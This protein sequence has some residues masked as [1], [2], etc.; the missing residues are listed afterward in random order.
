MV[1]V[2][3]VAAASPVR[4][5]LHARRDAR[6][7]LNAEQYRATTALQDVDE[8]APLAEAQKTTPSEEQEALGA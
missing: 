6:A 1:A 3:H 4:A 2:L 7:G 8:A 5:K